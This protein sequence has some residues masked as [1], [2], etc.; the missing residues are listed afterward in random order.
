MKRFFI[1]LRLALLEDQA[2]HISK[3]HSKGRLTAA[4]WADCI[5]PVNNKI[6]KLRKK[7]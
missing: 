3:E 7:L 2:K 1:R 4:Q 5:S 6:N